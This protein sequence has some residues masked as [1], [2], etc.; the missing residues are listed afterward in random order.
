[1][2]R[3]SPLCLALAFSISLIAA[4]PDWQSAGERWWAHIKVL[5][6][7]NMEGR[8][9]GS[10]GYRRAADYVAK[11]FTSYGIQPA[12]EQG[13]L[14]PV[15]FDVQRVIAAKSNLYYIRDSK[16]TALRLGSDAILGV[17][18]PQP[19]AIEAPLVF[20][21]YGLHLPEAGFDDFAGQDLKGKII[22]I[23]NGGPG[24]LQGALKA[25]AKSPQEF[26]KVVEASGALGVVTIPN[27]KHMDIP[28]ERM[29]TAASMP[30]M[31][32]ADQKL[33]DTRG[34]MFTATLNPVSATVLFEGTGH[35]L[36]EL[37]SLV[38]V[39]K[40]LPHFEMGARLGAS[41]ATST[42][43]V[44]SPN[45]IGVLP[46]ADP[47]LK[48]E[49]VAL[50][51]HLDHVGIGEPINGDK[52][53]NGAM[54]DASGVATLLDIAESL[55]RSHAP[56]K[57]SVLFVVVCGEEKG[58]L[59]SRYFAGHP[60]VPLKSLAADLNT[61]M[62]LPLYPLNY[63]TVYGLEEST[64][65]DNIRA[66]AE[67][68][69]V[70]V[71]ADREPDRNVFIRSD[72]YNF[73]RAGVPSVMTAFD[74]LPG[75][76]EAAIRNEWFRLRYHAPSDDLQ[77]PVDLVAA[78]RFNA[79]MLTLTERIANSPARPSWKPDSFFKRFAQ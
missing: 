14:Q 36:D 49:Y 63:I 52:L 75:S 16:K 13:Y 35:T 71:N 23:V 41:V 39:A 4:P 62:F 78:A 10:A 20:L 74:A 68:M 45:V 17:R 58:L 44:E 72:Q 37:F 53:Y 26:W 42:E 11:K 7:D 70:H 48:N 47:V 2:L 21:G 32:L 66:V 33:Q 25:H 12:G 34:L 38:D 57:R 76:P 65:G 69:D 5:A 77:Q 46:G 29:A 8:D 43:Q 31:R 18:L 22:V 61:D 50:S 64:I 55:H 1:M 28:W 15:K 40:P 51:A 3:F 9:T 73:I 6:D 79:L 54:D 67:P 56:L 27:P 60:T 59:G 30:G 24:N 19:K